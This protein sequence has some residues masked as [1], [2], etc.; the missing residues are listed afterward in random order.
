VSLALFALVAAIWGVLLIPLARRGHAELAAWAPQRDT[1]ARLA[2]GAR[3]WTTG[4]PPADDD[5][6][7]EAAAALALHARRRAA[8]RRTAA[9]RRRSLLVLA[10]ATAAGLRAW[11][12]LG[13]RWWVAPAAAGGLLAAYL[14]VLVGMAWRRSRAT[15]AW[16]RPRTAR[17][18]ERGA[19]RWRP[20]RV[21]AAPGC[22]PVAP[23]TE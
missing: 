22:G 19:R 6:Y 23:T 4:D 1:P 2:R 21:R 17:L 12:A 13:G 9:R 11:A 20:G 3:P 8:R 10:V 7:P 14:A 18:V 5:P 15:I 16:R